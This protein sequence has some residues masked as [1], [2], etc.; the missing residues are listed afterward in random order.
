MLLAGCFGCYPS[1]RRLKG[2]GRCL[3]VAAFE[4]TGWAIA[5]SS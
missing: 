2:E 4:V 3:V 5:P 1:D